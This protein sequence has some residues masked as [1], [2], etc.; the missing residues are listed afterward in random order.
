MKSVVMLAFAI[1]ALILAGCATPGPV[2]RSTIAAVEQAL[3]AADLAAIVYTSSPAADPA[4]KARIKHDAQVAHDVFVRLRASRDPAD[5][6][7]LQAAILLLQSDNPLV[8]A[9]P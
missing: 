4:V 9:T 6:A 1:A 2:P 8:K 3:T 5:L 7:L